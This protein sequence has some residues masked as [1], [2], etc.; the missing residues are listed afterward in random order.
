MASKDYVYLGNLLV[1]TYTPPGAQAPGA[2]AGLFFNSSDHLGHASP[3]HE[4][5]A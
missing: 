2:E 4:L 3:R 5:E 1:A